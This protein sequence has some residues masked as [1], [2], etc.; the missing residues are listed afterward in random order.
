MKQVVFINGKF[1]GQPCTGV[2]RFAHGIVQALDVALGEERHRHAAA[3]MSFRLAV[4]TASLANAP[5][6]RNIALHPVPGRASHHWEQFALP[7]ATGGKLLLNLSGS[8]P[9]FKR[10]QFCTFHDA[11]LYDHPSAYTRGFRAWYRVLFSVQSHLADGLLTV[12][13]FSRNRLAAH[14]KV[15][16]HRF[17]V[18]YN[19]CE[20]L[21]AVVSDPAVI[22]RLGLRERPYVL[23]VGSTNPTKNF[24]RL[25]WAFER[26]PPGDAVLVVAGGMRPDVF[27]SID[28]PRSGRVLLAGHVNDAE[29]RALYE[30]ALFFAFPSLYEGFGI[31]PLEAMRLGCPVLASHSASIPEV[32][33]DA[34][35]YVDATEITS[36]ALGLE[37]LLR[38]DLLRRSLSEKGR[39]RAAE[40]SWSRAADQ[41]LERLLRSRNRSAPES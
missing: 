25:A 33:A 30:S 14:L 20:H 40:F 4:P 16:E 26:L 3:S 17:T 32:C 36:I 24:A 9:M 35:Y 28:L 39:D 12:S 6:L 37:S 8:A 29:L 19:G 11:A 5:R 7:R 41:L 1:L 21:D 22:D 27:A 34:A 2:Q 15:E 13:N 38:D 23:A 31:P 10:R 18:L